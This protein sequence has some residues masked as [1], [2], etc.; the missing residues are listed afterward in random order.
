ML[1]PTLA[2]VYT[3]AVFPFLKEKLSDLKCELPLYLSTS[4]DLADS[5]DCL[6]WWKIHAKEL[7]M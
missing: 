5:I 7:P 3:L 2:M 6:D 1:E 4:V